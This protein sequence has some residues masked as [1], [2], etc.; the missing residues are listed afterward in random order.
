MQVNESKLA[1]RAEREVGHG[2]KAHVAAGTGGQKHSSGTT[3]GTFPAGNA[4]PGSVWS[5][6][7]WE[8]Q[9]KGMAQALQSV[10]GWSEGQG[11]GAGAGGGPGWG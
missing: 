8:C 3:A 11:Q 7:S 1:I 9:S 10:L 2:H 4:A 5:L 6:V